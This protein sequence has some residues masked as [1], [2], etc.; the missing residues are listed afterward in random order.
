[1]LFPYPL[2]SSSCSSNTLFYVLVGHS[3]LFLISVI[4]GAWPSH[5]PLKP[6]SLYRY[7]ISRTLFTRNTVNPLHSVVSTNERLELATLAIDLS[8]RV[9]DHKSKMLKC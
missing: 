6:V 9:S 3:R 4:R 1:M 5:S 7:L 8:S 2:K